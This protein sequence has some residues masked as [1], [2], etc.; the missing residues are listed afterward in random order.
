MTNMKEIVV[1]AVII[2]IA[3]IAAQHLSVVVS[4]SMEP[5]M[6]RGDIVVVEKTNL[7]GLGIQEFDPEDVQVGDIVVYDAKWVNEDV[8]HRVINVTEINGNTYY[9]IKGDNNNAADPYYVE[10]S[11]ISARV[12]THGDSPLIIPYIG[13]INLWLKGL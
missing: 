12:V 1:Y 2:I 10:P 6:Y 4:G 9:V 13:Y 8:I 3:L 5:V 7:M 11:Q